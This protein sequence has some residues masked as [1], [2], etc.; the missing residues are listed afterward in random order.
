MSQIQKLL[1]DDDLLKSLARSGCS[2]LRADIWPKRRKF[3]ELVIT[4]S[5]HNQGRR[6]RSPVSDGGW[7]ADWTRAETRQW[8]PPPRARGPGHSAHAL[9]LQTKVVKLDT[10]WKSRENIGRH[11]YSVVLKFFVER[12]DFT[13]SLMST[14]KQLSNIVNNK[15]RNWI[16][17]FYIYFRCKILYC[18]LTIFSYL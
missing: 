14:K 5:R 4:W 2:A 12:T 8:S 9:E 6:C 3:S 13:K 17:F 18:R 1:A 10:R 15:Q 7:A 11:T 16:L